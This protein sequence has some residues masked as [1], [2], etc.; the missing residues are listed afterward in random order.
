MKELIVPFLRDVSKTSPIA[1]VSFLL[2]G[3][4]TDAIGVVPWP[5]YNYRPDVD[6]TMAY[7]NDSIFIKYYVSEKTVSAVYSQPNEPVHKDSCVEFFL[8]FDDEKEYYNFEFNCTGTCLA[9]FGLDRE[10]RSL[11]PEQVIRMIR[12]QS[13]LKVVNNQGEYNIAWELTLMVPLEVFCHHS[14]VSLSGRQCRANFYKCGDDLPEPHFLAWNDI[15]SASPDF[16]LPEYFGK[17]VFGNQEEYLAHSKQKQGKH[18]T[19]FYDNT[20]II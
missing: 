13:Q 7:G 3:F 8:S 1:H 10:N 16:H 9:G 17:L 20:V 4:E 15:K 12:H 11:L 2:D 18:E 19:E 6:F 14:P 5:P